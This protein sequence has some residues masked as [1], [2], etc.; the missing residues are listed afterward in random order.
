MALDALGAYARGRRLCL[1]LRGAD[2][3]LAGHLAHA[4]HVERVAGLRARFS[5]LP[6][7]NTPFLVVCE[8]EDLVQVAALFVPPERWKVTV[9]GVDAIEV[10]PCAHP[11]FALPTHELETWAR[12][13]QLWRTES[14]RQCHDDAPHLLFSPAPVVARA[15]DA[16]KAPH[17]ATILDV[18]CGAGRDVTFLLTEARS[19]DAPWRAT[20]LDRW[21]AALQRAAILL[22]DNRLLGQAEKEMRGLEGPAPDAGPFAEAILPFTILDDGR[23]QHDTAVPWSSLLLPHS[24]YDLILLIRFWH[25]PFLEALPARTAPGTLVVLSHFVHEPQNVDA[26]HCGTFLGTYD[27][28]PPPARIQ[29]GDIESLLSLWNESGTWIVVQNRIEPIEDQRP[30]Q[31]VLAQRT[32]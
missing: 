7:R 11:C 24:A 25:R 1:D 23:I 18:G 14:E 15:L 6:A 16:W 2:A 29:P 17:D 10:P 4:V 21:K 13:M 19:R 22:D 32:A 9:L 3:F 8:A 27:S 5:T 20:L 30:V 26:E 31:S 28:P 12:S